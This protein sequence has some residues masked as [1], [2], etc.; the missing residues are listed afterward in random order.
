MQSMGL[1]QTSEDVC[2]CVT[3]ALWI[4]VLIHITRNLGAEVGEPKQTTQEGG[5]TPHWV[6]K[7]T[8]ISLT[9]RG[10]QVCGEAV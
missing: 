4:A 10:C 2:K 7:C 8:T 9:A 3:C 5:R 6:L 1:Q